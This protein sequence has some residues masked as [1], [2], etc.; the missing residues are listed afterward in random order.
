MRRVDRRGGDGHRRRHRPA[1]AVRPDPAVRL[2]RRSSCTRATPRSPSAGPRPSPSTRACSPSCSDG[3][4]C[5]SC[6]TPTCSPR[7]RPSCSGSPR[8]GAARDAEGVADLLRLLGPLTAAEVAQRCVPGAEP[9]RWLADLAAARRVVEVRMAGEERWCARRGRRPGSA[10]ALGVPVPPG[11]P[12]AFTE[13]VEDPLGDL[14]GRYARTHGPFVAAA[15]S[16]PGSGSGSRWSGTR[17]TGSALAAGCSRAS[18]GPTGSRRRVVRRRGAAAAAPPLAGAAPQGG[19]A[20]STRR[21]WVGSCRPGSGCAPAA[22]GGGLRG[23][24]GVLAV[25]EQLA[26]LPA[27]RLRAGVAGAAGAGHG[28]PAVVPRRADRGRRGALGRPRGAARRRRLGL[29]PPG[30]PGVADA[31]RHRPV[32]PQRAAPGGARRPGPAAAPGSSG[33]WPRPSRHPTTRR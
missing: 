22:P 8:T 32:R 31:A 7:S 5:A 15:R 3:P 4:S 23:V 6:S 25:V 21:R 9:A 16:P 18:S 17:C 24:D 26:G 12:E 20:A 10:T 28:L 30:R 27:P 1:L 33:S 2:R 29:A 19:R 11:T 14:V 13:P